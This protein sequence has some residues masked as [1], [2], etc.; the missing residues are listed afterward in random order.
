MEKKDMEYIQE[1][2][3]ENK[4]WK[5]KRREGRRRRIRKIRIRT[6]EKKKKGSGLRF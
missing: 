6:G 1:E 4:K 5:R 2:N 3:K